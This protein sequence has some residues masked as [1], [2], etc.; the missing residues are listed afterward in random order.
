MLS[1]Q[2]GI[3]IAQLAMGQSK[4]SLGRI[5]QIL[6]KISQG[7]CYGSGSKPAFLE[8]VST[9]ILLIQSVFGCSLLL[10]PSG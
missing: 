8:M 4:C 3:D 2:I 9:S 5:M 10:H 7:R 1:E 6:L